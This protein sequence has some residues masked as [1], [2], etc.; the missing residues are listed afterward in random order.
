MKAALRVF[1]EG[2]EDEACVRVR[3]RARARARGGGS[4]HVC[5]CL[6]EQWGWVTAASE[7]KQWLATAGAVA[8][9]RWEQRAAL[10]DSVGI[11]R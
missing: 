11:P 7:A 8:Q 10:A 6:H 2:G 9:Q 5:R 3:A 4:R 1:C